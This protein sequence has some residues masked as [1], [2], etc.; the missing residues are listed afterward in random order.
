VEGMRWLQ[1]TFAVRFNRLRQGA[2]MGSGF[3]V[4]DCRR[5]KGGFSKLMARPL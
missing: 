4:C 1:G 3:V 5:D 2:E